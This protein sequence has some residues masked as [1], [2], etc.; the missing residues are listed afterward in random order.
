ML[1]PRLSVFV[2]VAVLTRLRPFVIAATACPLLFC[3][4]WTM[5]KHST[6]AF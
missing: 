6:L 3:P 1:Y 4:P 5:Y 2:L